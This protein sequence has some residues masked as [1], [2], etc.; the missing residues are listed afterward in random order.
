MSVSIQLDSSDLEEALV[1][2]RPLL[3]FEPASMMDA[4]AALG[5]SQTRRRI[6]SEKTAPDGTPWADNHEGTSILRQTGRNLLDSVASRSSATDAEWGAAWEFAHVHQYGAVIEPK[7]AKALAFQI[8]GQPVF[9]KRVTIPARPFVGLSTG[10]E[11]EIEDLV[12][13]FLGLGGLK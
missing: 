2:L 5:E 11:A 12:T 10:N 9:A 8:G 6:E 7:D 4:I 3:E 1:R 13:D